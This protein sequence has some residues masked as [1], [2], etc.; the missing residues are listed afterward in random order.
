MS[1]GF[2]RK[3]VNKKLNKLQYRGTNYPYAISFENT[4]LDWYTSSALN[5]TGLVQNK[6]YDMSF[7]P[8][9]SEN[10]P[11]GTIYVFRLKNEN[12]F[13]KEMVDIFEDAIQKSDTDIKPL[14]NLLISFHKNFRGKEWQTDGDITMLDNSFH[15]ALQIA[16]IIKSNSKKTLDYVYLSNISGEK[17]VIILG[18]LLPWNPTNESVEDIKNIARSIQY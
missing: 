8:D 5:A 13:D 14:L 7:F 10:N 15:P 16:G 12:M 1:F 2:F 18:S 6:Y 9:Y 3:A 17:A 4:K 11:V